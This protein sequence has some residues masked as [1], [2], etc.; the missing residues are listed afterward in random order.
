M[1]CGGNRRATPLWRAEWYKAYK[2]LDNRRIT[3]WDTVVK[4]NTSLENHFRYP[5]K[6]YRLDHKDKSTGRAFRASI[7]RASYASS[8]A[9]NKADEAWI[10]RILK[11]IRFE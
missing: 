11:S 1:E 10:T 6:I 9:V 3:Q 5:Q 4:L 2:G 7:V 8:P